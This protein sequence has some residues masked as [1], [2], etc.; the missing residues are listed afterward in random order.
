MIFWPDIFFGVWIFSISAAAVPL[1]L[2]T[3][4]LRSPYPLALFF[5][6][7]SLCS[8]SSSYSPSAAQNVN[9]SPRPTPQ[10]LAGFWDLLQL[11]IEDISL[12]FDEL[13]HL[14]SNEWQPALSAAAAQSPPDRKVLPTPAAQ[15]PGWGRKAAETGLSPPTTTAIPPLSLP[16]SSFCVCV[17]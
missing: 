3:I 15:C 17:P 12:K 7:L 13:Y 6:F 8:S 4:L 16:S 9:A 11:S 1:T 5:L 2:H 14:K 10:D